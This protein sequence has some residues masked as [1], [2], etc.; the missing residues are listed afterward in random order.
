MFRIFCLVTLLSALFTKA[1]GQP[2]MVSSPD[3]KIKVTITLTKGELQ[4]TVQKDG[5][6]WIN[7]SPIRL[8]IAEVPVDY[9]LNSAQTTSHDDKIIPVVHEKFASIRD[10]YNLL[11]LQ[12]ENSVG[13]EFRAYDR[14]VA[15]RWKSALDGTITIL[16]EQV[17]YVF[18]N[19]DQVY[20]A[21][22]EGFYSHNE[23]IFKKFAL[24]QLSLDSLGSLPALVEQNSHYMHISESDLYNYPGLWL[25]GTNSGTL[26]GTFPHYPLQERQ[27]RDR[28]IMVTEAANFLVKTPGTRTF[29]WRTILMEDHAAGLLTN[30]LIYQLNRPA[31]GDFSWVQPGKVQWDWW[32]ALNTYGV[33]FESGVNTA[34][35]KH[36]IDFAAQNGIPYIILD[37]GWSPTTDVTV[38]VPE[39]NVPE[40]AKYGQEKGVSLILW[41]LWNALDKDLDKA[42]TEYTRWGIK[43]IKVDFM[44]RNDAEMVNYYERIARATAAHHLLLDFH[45]CY[46]PTGFRHE[47]P[48]AMTR[49][50]VRGNEWSKWDNSKL[51][52]PEHNLTL[53][54]TRMVCGPMDYTPGAMLNAQLRDWS[55]SFSRPMSLGTRCHQLAMY[56]VFESPLQMLCDVPENYLRESESF[57]FLQQVPTTWEDTRV[58]DAAVGDYIVDARLGA[59]GNWYVGAMTDWTPRE[60]DVTLDFLDSGDYVLEYWADG[61]NANRMAQ[62]YKTGKMNVRKGDKLHLELAQ[63]GGYV[64]VIRKK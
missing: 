64:A 6:T 41:V 39:V 18:N 56:V 8:D 49:E 4:Y 12:F 62:D 32:N 60:L 37:E 54:F 42:M 21:S 51:T 13:L 44:Q 26:T 24:S 61:I 50:G 45:G 16:G 31:E 36:Y 3:Q 11:D 55:P 28:D 19:G 22:E 1:I 52:G 46:K 10:Q 5:K 17:T 15:W 48:N 14:G 53:P 43:G 33:D 23:R 57:A 35:Y 7:A 40:L 58:L 30:T 29:P 20:Y 59:D 27:V 63:G 25:T 2:W 34:T 47:F 38:S 9:T